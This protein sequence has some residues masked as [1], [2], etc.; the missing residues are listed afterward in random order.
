MNK[1]KSSVPDVSYTEDKMI[2]IPPLFKDSFIFI[3]MNVF[4]FICVCVYVY[5]V[6]VLP[7]DTGNI[8]PGTG[9]TGAVCQ[10]VGAGNSATSL[11]PSSLF[12]KNSV[13]ASKDMGYC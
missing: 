9:V 5:H 6:H 3:C 10:L 8:S 11:A 4:A 13:T 1:T 7:V 12:C 2:L